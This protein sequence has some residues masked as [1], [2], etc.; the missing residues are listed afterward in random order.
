MKQRCIAPCVCNS[1]S[2]LLERT[3]IACNSNETCSL[4]FMP[5]SA[6]LCCQQPQA[7]PAQTTRQPQ[8]HRASTG[9]CEPNTAAIY[10]QIQPFK[11]SHF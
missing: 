5:A 11:T 7:A 2:D 8:P 6:L 9:N 4:L 3:N 10:H 1:P